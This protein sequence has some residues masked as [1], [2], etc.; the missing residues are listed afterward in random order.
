LE[1][2]LAHLPR[3]TILEYRK[4]QSIYTQAQPSPGICLII[5]GTVKVCRVANDGRQVVAD[6]YRVDEFFGESVLLGPAHLPEQAIALANTRIMAWTAGQM[7][8]IVAGRPKLAVAIWQVLVQRN[9]DFAQ[10]IESFSL[11]NVARRLAR[12]L[13][14]LAE[15]LGAPAENGS[16]QMTA[17]T[18]ELLSQYVGT[19]REGITYHM[20]YFRKKGCL[21]YSRKG[22]TLYRDVFEE[23]LRQGD[24]HV[25]QPYPGHHRS[26]ET[27]SL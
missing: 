22:I 11:D 6:I 24:S 10:R 4:G 18:H 27:A 2:P 3:S 23:W 19:S 21:R 20:N 1:D 17:L 7:E 13:I 25:D 26:T 16:V 5:A 14:R 12:S 15:R 9:L 8:E